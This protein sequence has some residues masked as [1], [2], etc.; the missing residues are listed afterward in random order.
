M[1]NVLDF[2]AQNLSAVRTLGLGRVP[3]NFES[4]S[5]K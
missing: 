3:Y 2:I 1:H 4:I 5:V